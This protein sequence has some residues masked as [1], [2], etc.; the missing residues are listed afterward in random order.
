MNAQFQ[1]SE[2]PA[3][4]DRTVLTCTNYACYLTLQDVDYAT[5]DASLYAKE[6]V[7]A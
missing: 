5:F 2:H 4:P 6:A 3:I 7:T 1:P